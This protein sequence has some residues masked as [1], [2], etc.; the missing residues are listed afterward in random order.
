[1]SKRI[2]G[3]VL[4]L[5]LC[6][7]TVLFA[8][9]KEARELY[10]AKKY[11]EA[12]AEYE[13][14]LPTLTGSEK[15]GAQFKIGSCLLRFKK[16]DE[17]IEAFKKVAIIDGAS[18]YYAAN[19]QIYIGNCL[20][21]QKKYAEAIT[22]YEKVL[23][24]EGVKPRQITDAYLNIGITFQKQGKKQESQEAFISGCLVE[25]ISL[26]HYKR[27]FSKIKKLEIGK[28]K[29][30]DLLSKMILIIPAVP[31]NASFLSLLKSELEK[32]K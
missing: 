25:N 6:L 12:Q 29:Y 19:A 21:L 3:L 2:V 7:G 16:Y 22:A 31:E 13:K 5:I 24:I 32:L 9:V 4:G 8:G 1:M 14:A 23:L 11:V 26:N 18:V 30:Q 10:G 28:E 27:N 15:A 20:L 17:A